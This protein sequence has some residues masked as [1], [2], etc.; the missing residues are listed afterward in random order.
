[1]NLRQSIE[2]LKLESTKEEYESLI[3]GMFNKLSKREKRRLVGKEN[4]F[5]YNIKKALNGKDS[6]SLR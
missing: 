2:A 1:M 3:K 5:A 6:N 4:R